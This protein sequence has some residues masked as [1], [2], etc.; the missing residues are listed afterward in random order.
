MRVWCSI[1]SLCVLDSYA[2]NCTTYPVG[3]LPWCSQLINFPHSQCRQCLSCKSPIHHLPPMFSW[4]KRLLFK[5]IWLLI[6]SLS[7][8]AI[9]PPSQQR[10]YHWENCFLTWIQCSFI[11][12]VL[13]LLGETWTLWG[14]VTFIIII[15]SMM[16]LVFGWKD[17]WTANLQSLGYFHVLSCI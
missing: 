15:I 12:I 9:K 10:P 3:C 6:I 14:K 4:S 1:Y 13:D 11:S 17:K 8:M 7:I 5:Q 2:A 16:Q